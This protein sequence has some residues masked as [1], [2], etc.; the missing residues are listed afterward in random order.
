[1]KAS[2]ISMSCWGSDLNFAHSYPTEV[3]GLVT[4]IDDMLTAFFPRDDR[5]YVV[6]PFELDNCR[7]IEEIEVEESI[8]REAIEAD[9]KQKELCG[10]VTALLK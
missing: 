9:D 8:L 2:I 3:S 4:K 1:M 5:V 10:Q 6:A 7:I